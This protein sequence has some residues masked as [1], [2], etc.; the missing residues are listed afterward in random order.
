MPEILSNPEAKLRFNGHTLPCPQ[1]LTLDAL[2]DT[3]GVDVN[4]V[5]T[6]VNGTFVPRSL[7]AQTRLSPGDDAL[8]FQ[9]IVGG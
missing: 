8:T 6:A 2:L 3:Q 5:A 1:G 4:Q 9:A 7:R